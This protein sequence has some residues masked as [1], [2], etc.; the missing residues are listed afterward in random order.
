MFPTQDSMPLNAPVKQTN[1]APEPLTHRVSLLGMAVCYALAM[2]PALAAEWYFDFPGLYSLYSSRVS[3][4]V[5]TSLVIALLGILFACFTQYCGRAQRAVFSLLFSFL[6]LTSLIASAHAKLYAAPIS[7]GA[8]DALLGTDFHEATEFLLFQFSPVLAFIVIGHGC[9][10][11]A[12]LVLLRP[13]LAITPVCLKTHAVAFTLFGVLF[14]ASYQNPAFALE[15][16]TASWLQPFSAR[17]GTLNYQVPSLR[18]MV[19]MKDWLDYRQWLQASQAKRALYDFHAVTNNDT[20]RTMVLVV[21]ESMR[22]GNLSLY[23]YNK[24]TT[25]K[26]DARRHELLAFKNAIAPANQTIPSLTKML[27]PATVLAPDTFL[28]RPSIVGAAKQAGYKTFWISNQGRVGNFDSMI[29]LFAREADVTTYTNTEFYAGTHD[30]ILLDP[31]ANALQDPAPMK[32]IVL[33]LQGSHQSYVKRY[34]QSFAVFQPS[35]YPAS[36][37]LKKADS[38]NKQEALAKYDNSIRYTDWLL[39]EILQKLAV[40]PDSLMVYVSDHG[41]R[42]YESHVPS[43]GHGYP[44]PTRS[45]VEI[46]YLIWCQAGCASNI[47]A[48]HDRHQ[49]TLFSG[50]HLFHNLLN[51]L[52]IQT[53]DYQPKSDILNPAFQPYPVKVISTSKTVYGY[54]DLP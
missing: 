29:S 12:G 17:F 34:P 48:A 35:D 54:N 47:R 27:T 30:N 33:H 45:E 19:N 24:A 26:L 8:I 6:C 38:R 31:L 32:F 22:R 23:G 5:D 44:E 53:P 9:L 37:D 36:P 50:E 3:Y 2:L 21:G 41:E 4:G 28:E 10:M 43:C 14:I 25:P 51:L 39:D 7:V 42:F 13:R 16:R 20:P 52:A 49:H 46:P 18:M 40:I 15:N 1:P 11:S